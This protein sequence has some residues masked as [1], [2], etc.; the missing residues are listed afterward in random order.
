MHH[1]FTS[2]RAP[3]LALSRRDGDIYGGPCGV[4]VGDRRI[5]SRCTVTVDG[6]R[7][8]ALAAQSLPRGRARFVGTPPTLDDPALIVERVRDLRAD[9]AVETITVTSHRREASDVRV[10]VALGCDLASIAQVRDDAAPAELESAATVDGMRWTHPDGSAVTLSVTGAEVSGSLSTCSARLGSGDSARL[11]LRWTTT[12]AAAAGFGAADHTALTAP[13]AE[14][15]DPHFGALL[16][17]SVA[18]LADL[19]LADGADRFYAAGAP[20]YLTLFGRDSLWSAELALPLGTEVAAGTLNALARRQGR[21]HDVAAA[22]EPGKILHELRTQASEI[23]GMR[24][25]AT[26]YGTVDATPLWISLL[27]RA[28]RW[29]LAS[30][31]VA[32]LLPNLERALGWVGEQTGEG[33]VRYVDTTGLGLANQGWKDSVDAVQFAD[34]TLAAAPVA[35]CEVQGYAYAAAMRGADLLDAFDRPGG[36]GWRHWAVRLAERF[37]DRFWVTDD[38]GPYPAIA[39]DADDRPA[40]T[41]TSNMGHLLGTGLLDEAESAA[42]VRRLA[43]P[44]MDSGLGLRT[45]SANARGFNPLS[46]HNGSVWPHDNAIILAGLR[47]VGTDDADALAYQLVRGLLRGGTAFDYRFPE[48][49][50]GVGDPPLPYPAS[51]R[52]QAWSAASA[53]EML[54]A[55][56]GIEPDVPNGSLRIIPLAP[57]PVGALA[58]RSVPLAGGHL[59]V[60]ITAGGAVSVPRAPDGLAVFLS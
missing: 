20:W 27:H 21:R 32:A 37:R 28:W 17:Q 55:V 22:E 8:V 25:P 26:Y 5:I 15:D 39:L 14:T 10:E 18:D 12:T 38:V 30:D 43:A 46:Y 59:D 7:L 50:G 47:R 6:T 54:R 60:E 19:E 58:V 36:A 35:L 29:G 31:A 45:M 51:C 9:G 13:T 1:L 48:V 16:R 57:S 34:A 33:F 40:D 44:D 49:Y 24:L 4:F 11:V 42:V 52:P 23:S 53:V 56:L 2:V 41:P 3:A